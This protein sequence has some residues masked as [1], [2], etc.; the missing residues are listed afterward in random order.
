MRA[1]DLLPREMVK[2]YN[3][4]VNDAAATAAQAALDG[5]DND[6]VQ[7]VWRGGCVFIP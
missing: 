5:R 3:D 7:K 2:A 1:D 4:F 6:A